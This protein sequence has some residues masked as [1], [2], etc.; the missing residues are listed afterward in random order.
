VPGFPIPAHRVSFFLNIEAYESSG[1]GDVI[2]A[3]VLNISTIMICTSLMTLVVAMALTFIWIFEKREQAVAWWCFSMWVGTLASLTLALRGIAPW[4]VAIGFGNGLVF[5]A[6]ALISAGFASF[7]GRKMGLPLILSGA[8]VWCV[9][10]FGFESIRSDVNNRIILSSLIIPFYCVF[11]VRDTMAV[12]KEERLP[13]AMAACLFYAS[14]GVFYLL[15]IP[16][17]I[18]YPVSEIVPGRPST[19]FAVIT[20][21]AF[22]HGMLISFVFVAL[23]RERTERRYRLAAE[24]DSLTLVASRRFFV[25]E[26][27][28]LLARRPNS[29]F[30]A[31]LDLDFFKSIND[32]YGHMAGDKVLQSFAALVSHK[33][34]PGMAFGRLGGE[35]FGLF[36]PDCSEAEAVEFLEDLRAAVEA[37]EIRFNGNVLKATTSIGVAGVEEAG[38]DFD[39]LMAGADNALYVAK[40]GG[41]NRVS[42]FRLAMRLEKI[43]E[44]GEE[45]RLS[46]SKQRVSR[47]SVRSRPGRV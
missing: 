42:V 47:L 5:I 33:L 4:W 12:W 36:L 34:Q 6:Y 7:C 11:V 10:N 15:R 18:F 38:L 30:L 41:R 29:G 43:V 23:I 37:L 39:H 21:E 8:V 26:T 27:R 32:S 20:L 45:S 17:S 22:V 31:V 19:W 44:G 16:F 46:L 14:H 9:C 2:L 35:E 13:S 3:S 25:S 28:A 24:I 40:E 1:F